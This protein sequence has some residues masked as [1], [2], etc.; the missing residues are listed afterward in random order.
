MCYCEYLE[1]SDI[2]EELSLSLRKMYKPNT[3][4]GEA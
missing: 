1:L 2:M 4:D 3:K